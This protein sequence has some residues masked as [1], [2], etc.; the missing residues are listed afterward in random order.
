MATQ[1]PVEKFRAGQ[2]GCALWE[3]A[4]SFKGQ[5]RMLLKASLSKRYKAEDGTWKSSQS[6]SRDEIPLAIYCLMMAFAAIVER[7]K[8]SQEKAVDEEAV[9]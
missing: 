9:V 4:V 2:V 6:F 3:N 5:E 1:T 8:D 7:E